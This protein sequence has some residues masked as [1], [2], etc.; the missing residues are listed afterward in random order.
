LLS[1]A[2]RSAGTLIER[3][4]AR[5]ADPAPP[6]LAGDQDFG[7]LG[8][9]PPPTL[10]PAAVLIALVR[11]PEP[12]LLLTTRTATLRSHSGQVAFPGGRI[13]ADDEGP[14]GAALR[15]AREEIGLAPAAVQILGL[16]SRY[17]TGTGYAVQPVIG[18]IDP[19]T[20]LVP[21]PA[22]VADLFEV[23]LAF[24]LDPANHLV[25]ET[26]WQGRM[27][28]YFAIEWQE[29]LIWGAT[30]GMLVNLAARL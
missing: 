16:G 25:R 12:G 1:T 9:E 8:A 18:A 22:E 17:Q 29:R 27:R 13:D 5:L 26:M 20:E 28:R 30:A 24:V 21:N 23:P 6:R 3:L 14:V 7:A 2:D 4:H 15:E 11:R 10:V 19:D